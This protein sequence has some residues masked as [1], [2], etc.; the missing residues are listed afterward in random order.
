[1]SYT[2]EDR[3]AAA[4]WFIDIHDVED[5]SPELL[6][7][8]MRWM[9]ASAAHRLAFDVVEQVWRDSGTLEP[10]KLPSIYHGERDGYDGSVPVAVWRERRRQ[11]IRG[12]WKRQIWRGGRG[13]WLA[14]AAA[15]ALAAMAFVAAP[16]LQSLIEQPDTADSFA[17]RIGEQMQVTL[18]DGS[19]VSL[20][21]RSRLTVAYTRAER[22]VRLESGEAFFAVQKDASRPF[23]V[24]VLDGVVTAVGTAFDVRTTND[25]VHV[26]V[27]EG[28]VQVNGAAPTLSKRISLSLTGQGK[29][30]PAIVRLTRGEAISFQSQSAAQGSMGERIALS[31]VD[32]S[33]PARWR[34]GWLV[35]R[36]E[37]LRE[38]LADVARYVDRDLVVANTSAMNSHFTGAIYK[39]SVIEWLESLPTA[40]AVSVNI[41]DARIRIAG[42]PA[43]TLGHEN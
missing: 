36:D 12:G 41:D 42:V 37:P 21:A 40:F 26:A 17:T 30:T 11:R 3:L 24:H 22:N 33:E 20:G 25:R 34:D 4:E 38:V 6:H 1:M 29:T 27:S 2:E 28:T 5:P 13:R 8:W 19:Q 15:A 35:Y 39:D 23:R 14:I 10:P 7:N 18:P 43:A 9:E 31:R 32:P 16:R